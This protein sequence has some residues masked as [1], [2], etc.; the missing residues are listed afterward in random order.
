MEKEKTF[1]EFVMHCPEGFGEL[2]MERKPPYQTSLTFGGRGVI[3]QTNDSWAKEHACKYGGILINGSAFAIVSVGKPHALWVEPGDERLFERIRGIN[4]TG[5]CPFDGG[6]PIDTLQYR[7]FKEFHGSAAYGGPLLDTLEKIHPTKE[8]PL[9][10]SA[11]LS[12]R[13]FGPI[14]ARTL[15]DCRKLDLNGLKAYS[16]SLD[17]AKAFLDFASDD[18][19]PMAIMSKRSHGSMVILSKSGIA[20][21]G[22]KAEKASKVFLNGLSE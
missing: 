21:P 5:E 10:Y 7:I 20:V 9:W 18:C 2:V 22:T 14:V 13:P 1:A 19:G 3:N 4:E 12:V 6:K 17:E 8:N 16:F 11:I 15:T